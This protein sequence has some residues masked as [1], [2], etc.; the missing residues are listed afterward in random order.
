MELS[1]ENVKSSWFGAVEDNNISVIK[2]LLHEGFQ[3]NALNKVCFFISYFPVCIL[4]RLTN[5]RT[6]CFDVSTGTGN[7]N[8]QCQCI[9]IY[10]SILICI[11]AQ[12]LCIMYSLTSVVVTDT[13]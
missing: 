6:I 4:F 8:G 3:I 13:I 2:N 5:R 9:F 1:E 7:N 11:R 12:D 10:G